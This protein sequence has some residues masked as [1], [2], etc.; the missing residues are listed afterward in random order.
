MKVHPRNPGVYLFMTA[1]M[2]TLTQGKRGLPRGAS[3]RNEPPES[4]AHVPSSEEGSGGGLSPFD[5]PR[6]R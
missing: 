6:E 1:S 5:A 4:C 3:S 2:W